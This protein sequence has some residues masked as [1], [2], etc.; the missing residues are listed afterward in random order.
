MPDNS[1][2]IEIDASQL[3]DLLEAFA[4]VPKSDKVSKDIADIL[5]TALTN[6]TDWAFENESDPN[7]GEKWPERII[8]RQYVRNLMRYKKRLAT[9]E[10]RKNKAKNKGKKGKKSAKASKAAPRPKKPVE[11]KKPHP[12][13]QLHT[14]AA[15]RPQQALA[16]PA[17]AAP[18]A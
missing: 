15:A 1:I 7:T 12:M 10:E 5:K 2:R 16:P 17:L 3:D 9:W 14:P 11:P 6:S 18:I 8:D 13:L 4:A